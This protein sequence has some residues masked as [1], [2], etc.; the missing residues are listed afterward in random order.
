[1]LQNLRTVLV[2]KDFAALCQISSSLRTTLSQKKQ[3]TIDFSILL[4]K[5]DVKRSYAAEKMLPQSF[6]E[7]KDRE[8]AA[9]ALRY[10]Y[11]CNNFILH[12]I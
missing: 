2:S 6:L 11:F 5:G 3:A 4:E 1:M 12:S 7:G 9:V 10:I 8:M